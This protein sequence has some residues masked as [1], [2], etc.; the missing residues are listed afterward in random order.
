MANAGWSQSQPSSTMPASRLRFSRHR[1]RAAVKSS[2]ATNRPARWWSPAMMIGSPA[3]THPM[4]EPTAA[5][6]VILLRQ[7]PASNSSQSIRQPTRERDRPT[8]GQ[9]RGRIV[10]SVADARQQVGQPFPLD[11][12]D[13]FQAR[14]PESRRW[15]TC[16][17]CTRSGARSNGNC[18]VRVD[19]CHHGLN[20]QLRGQRGT[21]A[22]S[23]VVAIIGYYQP[24]SGM[25]GVNR[26]GPAAG[27]WFNAFCR[28]PPGR[29]LCKNFRTSLCAVAGGDARALRFEFAHATHVNGTCRSIKS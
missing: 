10:R 7:S 9:L 21:S 3:A 4:Q 26:T 12:H 16:R 1:R 23:S 11:C 5:A 22:G 29:K 27:Y 8:A 15:P 28:K 24:P 20:R 13:G 19:D 14:Q 25:A 18:F 6:G 17:R 2:F